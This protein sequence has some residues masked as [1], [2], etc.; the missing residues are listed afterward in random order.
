MGGRAEKGEGREGRGRGEIEVGG[1][2]VVTTDGHKR[3]GGRGREKEWKK[4]RGAEER[5]R[6]G[7]GTEE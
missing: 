4:E 1:R 3:G 5:E 2:A 7:R 6:E